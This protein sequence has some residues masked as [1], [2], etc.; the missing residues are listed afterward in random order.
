MLENSF[1]SSTSSNQVSTNAEER[2]NNGNHIQWEEDDREVLTIEER[3]HKRYKAFVVPEDIVQP[4]SSRRRVPPML[5]DSTDRSSRYVITSNASRRVTNPVHQ[6][7][8]FTSIIDTEHSG[9]FPTLADLNLEHSS[10]TKLRKTNRRFVQYEDEQHDR[11]D[12]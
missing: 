10:G 7:D 8:G 2:Q 12:V 11:K 6:V 9:L 5:A 4:G 1:A 3:N